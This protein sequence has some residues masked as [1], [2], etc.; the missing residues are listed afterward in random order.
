MLVNEEEEALEFR[1]AC[2]PANRDLI[3]T[4]FPYDRG[5]AGYVFMTGMP[6]ATSN[7]REEVGS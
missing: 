2:G 3:G 7:V 5:I 1:V 4:R 6:I